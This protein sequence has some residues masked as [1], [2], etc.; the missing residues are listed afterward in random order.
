MPLRTLK[1]SSLVRDPSIQPRTELDKDSVQQYADAMERGEVFP[2]IT[3]FKIDGKNVV[4]AGWH[5]IAAAE[6]CNAASIR[7]EVH[8]GM[9]LRDAKLFAIS[10][11]AKHG[12]RLSNADKRRVVLTLLEDDEWATKSNREIAAQCG[13]SHEHVRRIKEER[14][15][16]NEE[17]KPE[18]QSSEP[19]QSTGGEGDGWGDDNQG[20]GSEPEKT[21]QE[22]GP[23][24]DKAGN[25]V[26]PN[27]IGAFT[28]GREFFS[29]AVSNL[30]QTRDALVEA[31][32][33]GQFGKFLREQD[34]SVELNNV[35]ES[36]RFATPHGVCPECAGK[37][38]DP[39]RQQGWMPKALYTAAI[40]RASR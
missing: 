8:D 26:P 15:P 27:L 36:L 18:P 5:R 11:N 2:P 31:A 20:G 32:K 10:D 9:T 13:V 30:S 29:A 33:N 24:V 14:E 7:A 28:E 21:K 39:C 40:D 35:I 25:V 12:V 23:L 19:E 37:G 22:S 1:I 16:K 3:V 6:A 17:P 34:I 4:A 38:C